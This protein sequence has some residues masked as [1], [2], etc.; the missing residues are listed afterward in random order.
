M[1]N[2]YTYL[3][4]F[5]DDIDKKLNLSEF[6]NIFDRPHQTIKRH[7]SKFLDRKILIIEKKNKFTFYYL[8]TSNPLIYEYLSIAEK[9]R[10]FEILNDPMFNRLYKTL[11]P[12]FRE[13][14]FLIF[15]SAV[16]T[17]DY[18]DLDLLVLYQENSKEKIKQEIA[19]FEATYSIEIHAIFSKESDLNQTFMNEVIKKHVILNDHGYFM[20]LF[21]E[22]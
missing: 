3:Q 18:S 6:E 21:H 5:S 20:R 14:K 16:N 19:N 10:L 17:K 4:V 13:N 22:K 9:E 8:N 15:G 1:V 12:Y 7:L 11:E 2:K